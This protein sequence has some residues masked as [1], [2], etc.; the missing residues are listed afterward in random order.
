MKI[1][2]SA[3]VIAI[4]GVAFLTGK[5]SASG[6]QIG[7][8]NLD[9]W[10]N[11]DPNATSYGL[12]WTNGP[13]APG[14]L[15]EDVNVTLLGGPSA[16]NMTELVTL[17]LADG[18]AYGDVQ[19]LGIGL[20]VDLTT[21]LY[22]VPG[23]SNNGTAVLELLLWLGNDTNYVA[24]AANGAPVSDSGPFDNSTGGSAEPPMIPAGLAGMPAMILQA[25][26]Q[27]WRGAGGTGNS[28]DDKSAA[29]DPDGGFS[30]NGPGG[31]SPEELTD[32]L[33]LEISQFLTNAPAQVLLTLHNTQPNIFYQL[34][35]RTKGMSRR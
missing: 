17:T 19:F 13:D 6:Q 12:I 23:V 7:L 14:L 29:S 34:Q 11:T 24:A 27:D 18:S 32:G 28:Q 5:Y 8:M 35:S 22:T 3:L 1:F 25:S 4:V 31:D 20:L 21:G 33:W 9:S 26:G 2:R 10:G 16:T 15:Q 30:P